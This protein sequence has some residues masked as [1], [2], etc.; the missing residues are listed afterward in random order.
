MS[1]KEFEERCK[2]LG[3]GE[4]DI[5]LMLTLGVVTRPQIIELTDTLLDSPWRKTNEVR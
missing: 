4:I 3:D 1:E 5:K 2:W